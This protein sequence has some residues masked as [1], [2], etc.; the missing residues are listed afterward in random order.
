MISQKSVA[1]G[2]TELLNK[3]HGCSRIR[4]YPFGVQCKNKPKLQV[5]VPSQM[6]YLPT[7]RAGTISHTRR[8]VLPPDHYLPDPQANAAYARSGVDTVLARGQSVAEPRSPVEVNRLWPGFGTSYRSK[9]NM[10]ENGMRP[11]WLLSPFRVITGNLRVD[12]SMHV[13]IRGELNC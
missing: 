10:R 4:T 13:G 7:W 2:R 3:K 8:G 5:G 1:V 6:F 12:G 11:E 9:T